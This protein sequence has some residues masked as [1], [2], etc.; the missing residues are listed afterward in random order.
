MRISP[1]TPPLIQEKEV[2]EGNISIGGARFTT[3]GIMFL[4]KLGNN[5]TDFLSA[6]QLI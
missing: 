4:K 6:K 3:G 1:H 5:L 2:R